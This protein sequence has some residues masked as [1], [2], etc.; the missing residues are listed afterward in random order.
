M[1]EHMEVQVDSRKIAKLLNKKGQERLAVVDD[2]TAGIHS[3]VNKLSETTCI[4]LSFLETLLK[5]DS[6]VEYYLLLE[7]PKMENH[8]KYLGRE[9]YELSKFLE[10]FDKIVDFDKSKIN[11]MGIE[12][13]DT[14]QPQ[15][16]FVLLYVL[17]DYEK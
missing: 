15:S 5:E 17:R 2:I 12:E 9:F 4:K 14:T 13:V 6:W 3:V 1:M 11:S 10:E 7:F 16:Y 8:V